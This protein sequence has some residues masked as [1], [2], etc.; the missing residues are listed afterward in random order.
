MCL[1]D[2]DSERENDSPMDEKATKPKGPRFLNN[3]VEGHLLNI[4]N[5]L[6]CKQEIQLV[7]YL[8]P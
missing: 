3:R 7:V 8:V 4:H 1:S 2:T 5:E 6:S